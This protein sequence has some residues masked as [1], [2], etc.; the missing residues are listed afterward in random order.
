L[1]NR[2]RDEEI[3]QF[4]ATFFAQITDGPASY[5]ED[6]RLVED[7]GLDSLDFVTLLTEIEE[8][9]SIR[10]SDQVAAAQL[11]T[12]ASVRGYIHRNA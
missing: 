8:R 11:A 3:S 2:Q 4:L 12:V 10:I 9:W 7:L 1:V 6:T 5:S